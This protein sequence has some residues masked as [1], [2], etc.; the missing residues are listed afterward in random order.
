MAC[1]SQL[2]SPNKA[3]QK[4]S[5]QWIPTGGVSLRGRSVPGGIRCVRFH[6]QV[7]QRPSEILQNDVA[8]W[9]LDL[10]IV[11]KDVVHFGIELGHLAGSAQNILFHV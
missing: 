3:S 4:G 7:S 1:L 5:E 8:F 2:V 6:I 11:L 10:F 9:W